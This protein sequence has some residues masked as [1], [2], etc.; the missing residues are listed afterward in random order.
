MAE[1]SNDDAIENILSDADA[2][3]GNFT[4][5]RY[6]NAD[7]NVPKRFVLSGI[8]E[9]PFGKGKTFGSGWTTVTDSLIGGWT[10]N[11]IFTLQDGYPYTVYTSSLRFPDRICDG[12]LPK[13]QRTPTRW[14]DYTCFPTHTPQVVTGPNGNPITIGLNGNAG[15]NIIRG[16]GTNNLDLGVHKN[17]RFTE[18]KLLQLRFE[19]FNALNH[20][21]YIGPSGTYFFNSP[22][23]AALTRAR[24][25][26]DIQV[27]IKFLF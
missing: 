16:P 27:A 9:L 21:N 10:L 22:S 6:S 19:A 12:N 13:S 26:R 8:Y 17:F 4:R 23:G 14:F 11:Y 25:N 2:A 7:F 5:R 15:P 24:D 3:T 18:S 20:A 1:S